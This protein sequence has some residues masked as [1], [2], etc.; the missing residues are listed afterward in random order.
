MAT[1]AVYYRQFFNVSY[2]LH[3]T[4]ASG[5]LYWPFLNERPNFKGGPSDLG[6]KIYRNI[7]ISSLYS[8]SLLIFIHK[9]PVVQSHPITRENR[10]LLWPRS[11]STGNM[12]Y[13]YMSSSLIYILKIHIRSLKNSVR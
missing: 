13:F 10:D 9:T 8:Q 12:V 3:K 6:T 2:T 7:K 4:I 11:T 5:M 1:S